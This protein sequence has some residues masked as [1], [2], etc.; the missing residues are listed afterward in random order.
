VCVFTPTNYL[1]LLSIH[2]A[3]VQDLAEGGECWPL[4][5][6]ACESPR[7]R[8]RGY[9]VQK[10]LIILLEV[11]YKPG[12]YSKDIERDKLTGTI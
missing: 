4:A 9:K 3:T 12:W 8:L 2:I 6:L 1:W 5:L 10:G 7:L 11:H